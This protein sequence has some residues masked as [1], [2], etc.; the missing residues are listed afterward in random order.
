MKP[1]KLIISAFGP[2]SDKMPEIYFDQFEEKGLFLISGDTG[3]GKTT[4]FDAICF[5]LYGTTSGTYRDTKNL[6]SEYAKPNTDS[7]VDFYFSHQGRE[8]HVWRQPEYERRKQ[9]GDGLITEKQ[10][11][12]LYIEGAAPIEGVIQVNNA[13]KELLH[14]DDKQFKQ[15]AMI[16]QGEFWDLLNAKTEQRTEILRTIFM[17]SGYKNIEYILKRRMDDNGAKKEHAEVTVI[18]NGSNL[19]VGDKGIRGIVIEIGSGMNDIRVEDT[20][21]VAGAG[22]LLSKVANAAAA[23]GLGGMEFAAGIPGSIGG[24]VTM[25]AGAY[26]GE[27]KDILESV[28]VIDPEGMM[29]TLSVEALDLSYR[30]SCI[31][32]KGGI[33][34]EATI[35]LEKKTEEEIRA[36]MADLRNRRVEKQPLEYPSAGS[37]FKRPEGYFAGKLIMDAGL[38]GYTVGGAQVS[39]KHCGF[40]I[41]HNNATAAD[42]CQLMQDVKDKVRKQFGVELDPEV[43]MIGEF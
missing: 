19:L 11:A 38:R 9:R 18:G 24:A 39:E 3:A 40:V 34:V 37:T 16:A 25:N 23:A 29:H 41:N 26:G 27:M 35:K 20:K 22:A 15:I 21:I 30:H 14:I 5:A 2:Y 36:Q 42:V 28:K 13:V 1:I 17:T 33:V 8:Y 12:T 43:K 31:M 32:E 10:K 4:I 7:F 6:R